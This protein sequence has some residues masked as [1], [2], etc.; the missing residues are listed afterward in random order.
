MATKRKASVPATQ[1]SRALAT[2][3][4]RPAQILDKYAGEAAEFDT[5]FEGEVEEEAP[6]NLCPVIEF[7]EPGDFIIGDYIGA[8][9]EVGPNSS[10][11]YMFKIPADLAGGTEKVVGIWGSTALDT[12]MD[13]WKPAP[14][15]RLQVIYTGTAPTQRGMNPVKT[16]K[17]RKLKK[18]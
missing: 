13:L 11:M 8:K 10:N 2:I 15:S 12:T 3:K 7:Q 9:P 4:G 1:G 6:S 14:G 17:I 18:K 5:G 16:Y